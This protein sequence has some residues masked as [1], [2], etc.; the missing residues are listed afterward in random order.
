M[1]E[2]NICLFF[3]LSFLF[4]IPYSLPYA[5]P[6]SSLTL[7]ST[8]LF[9]PIPSSLPPMRLSVASWWMI[10]STTAPGK[11]LLSRIHQPC[12]LSFK[13]RF[14]HSVHR[15]LHDH[16]S[17]NT[18]YRL[19]WM[20]VWPSIKL[21]SQCL[22]LP[23]LLYMFYLEIMVNW[24]DISGLNSPLLIL[25]CSC[26]WW[27]REMNYWTGSCLVPQMSFW[28]LNTGRA[29]RTSGPIKY[30]GADPDFTCPFYEVV[31]LSISML[32]KQFFFWWVNFC[33]LSFCRLRQFVRTNR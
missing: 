25:A 16:T 4:S 32:S 19:L 3:L 29:T 5:S 14:I 20:S 18:Q 6:L 21:L 33:C 26:L 7:L 22:P 11:T 28:I 2:L 15:F 12:S 8:L 9:S 10:Y 30:T 13:P 31:V 17:M 23:F 1:T 27:E 24:Q